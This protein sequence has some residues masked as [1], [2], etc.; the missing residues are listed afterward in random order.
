MTSII[1]T[2][3]H[4]FPAALVVIVIAMILVGAMEMPS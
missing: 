2:Y 4:S 1:N 3:A